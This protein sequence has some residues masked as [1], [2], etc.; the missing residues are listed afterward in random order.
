MLGAGCW[1]LD[2]KASV[3]ILNLLPI[4]RPLYYTLLDLNQLVSIVALI[5]SKSNYELPT[6][7]NEHL[8]NP[9]YKQ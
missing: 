4:I 9:S 6:N 8:F 3:V 5:I 7:N 2:I 1:M